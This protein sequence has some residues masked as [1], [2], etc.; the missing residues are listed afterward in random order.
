MCR[1]RNTPGGRRPGRPA[2][3][4]RTSVFW[5]GTALRRDL[6][7]SPVPGTGPRPTPG[8]I[9]G[10]QAPRDAGT[11][12]ASKKPK[13][14]N[15]PAARHSAPG[16]A[17]SKGGRGKPLLSKVPLWKTQAEGDPVV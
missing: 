13:D 8:A 11:F 17:I 4:R 6:L 5:G 16:D 9:A 3:E 15:G 14:R 12:P 1:S 10:R 2:P 7:V